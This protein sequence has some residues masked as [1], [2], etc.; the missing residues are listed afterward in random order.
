MPSQSITTLAKKAGI[1][2]KK[3]EEYWD[4]AKKQAD[5]RKTKLK[6]GSYY[7][8]CA[9]KPCCFSTWIQC[10]IKLFLINT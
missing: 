1:S 7:V 9:V 2:K 6:K 3:A 8:S 4:R 5:K 10:T